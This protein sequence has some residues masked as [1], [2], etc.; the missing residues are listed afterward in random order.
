MT[1]VKWT[2]KPM[3][4]SNEFDDMFRTVFH[5]DLKYPLKTKPNWKP[6]IDIKESDN[7]FQINT[8][9]PGL[10]KKDIKVSL[11]GDQ[12]TISGERK[13]ISDNEN[14]HYYYR[15]RSVGKFNRSFN[16]PESINKDKIQASFKNGILSIELEKHEEIVPKEMEISIS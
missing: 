3:D 6:E 15:E 12:L 9:L 13:R 8:D 4:I 10:T 1:L 5:S 7:L 16:L 14:D 11:K 2:P